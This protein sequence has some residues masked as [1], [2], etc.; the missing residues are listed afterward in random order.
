MMRKEQLV[1]FLKEELAKENLSAISF[2]NKLK[3]MGFDIS[4]NK[5]W[6]WID[7]DNSSFPSMSDL[8][9]MALYKGI[10]ITDLLVSYFNCPLPSSQVSLNKSL[11]DKTLKELWNESINISKE[12]NKRYN[13]IAEVNDENYIFSISDILK[14]L[15]ESET[16]DLISFAK[17]CEVSLAL[18]SSLVYSP[19]GMQYSV[20]A[21]TRICVEICKVSGIHEK[22]ANNV[23]DLI[24]IYFQN[25]SV[26]NKIHQTFVNA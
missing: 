22:A 19:H 7:I 10:S 11:S 2:A 16:I 13:Q 20:E 1:R 23:S 17:Q 4:A 3:R 12:I 18:I 9:K 8:E 25:L 6:R 24:D 14:H 5:I 15:L 26:K 21:F